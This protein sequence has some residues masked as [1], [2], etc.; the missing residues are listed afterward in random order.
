LVRNQFFN[1]IETPRV[2]NTKIARQ[3]GCGFSVILVGTVHAEHIC[4]ANATPRLKMKS[5]NETTADE[6]YT[7]PAICHCLKIRS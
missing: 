3:R 7:E 4:I 5:R 1:G 2:A 6:S